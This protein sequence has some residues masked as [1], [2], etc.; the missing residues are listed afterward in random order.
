MLRCSSSCSFSGRGCLESNEATAAR[1]QTSQA[2]D[3]GERKAELGRARANENGA[4]GIQNDHHQHQQ[5]NRRQ[6]R[7]I[8]Q[9]YL[10]DF[11]KSCFSNL[12][13]LVILELIIAP[14][15]IRKSSSDKISK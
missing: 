11:V 15:T 6:V 10:H 5:R 1:A 8:Q 4:E 2:R 13:R 12:R 14:F 9:T 7:P 3:G